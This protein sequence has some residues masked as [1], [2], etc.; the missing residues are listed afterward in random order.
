MKKTMMISALAILLAGAPLTTFAATVP[1]VSSIEHTISADLLRQDPAITV[2]EPTTSQTKARKIFVAAS[3]LNMMNQVTTRTYMTQITPTAKNESQVTYYVWY[4]ETPQ[5]QKAVAAGVKQVLKHII[6]PR[7]DAAAKEAAINNWIVQHVKPIPTYST[8]GTAYDALYKHTGVCNAF[9]WLAYE[10]L[11]QAHIP[12][13]LV[14]GNAHYEGQSGEH[15]WNEVD[16][17]GKWYMLDTTWDTSL[18]NHYAFF[19]LTSAQLSKTHTWNHAGLPIADTNFV[20]MLEHSKNPQDKQ[21]LRAI[22]G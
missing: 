14:V 11:T 21:I 9:A 4:R 19:N 2:T 16:L 6:K 15:A 5:Q 22:E 20:S 12:N 8:V 13:R 7:M 3:W 1:S 10:M 18:P 17:N